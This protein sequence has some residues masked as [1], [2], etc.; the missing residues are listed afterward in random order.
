MEM[1]RKPFGRSARIQDGAIRR[2]LDIGVPQP[3]EGIGNALRSTFRAGRD[4]VP[5]DMLDLLAKL[6]RH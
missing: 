2:V 3:H 5:E 4:S 6:D 1:Q